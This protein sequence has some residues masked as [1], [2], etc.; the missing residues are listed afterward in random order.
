MVDRMM[1]LGADVGLSDVVM[2]RAELGRCLWQFGGQSLHVL[3][4]GNTLEDSA[5]VLYQ[6]RLSEV[7]SELR[8]RFDFVLVDT[9]SILPLADVP[10]LC[11]DLDGAVLVVRAD[12]T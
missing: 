2:G 5:A 9:T 11:R 10:I 12:S 1:G 8:E 7:W 6:R 3:P 4:A